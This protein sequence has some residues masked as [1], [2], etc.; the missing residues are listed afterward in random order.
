MS[1]IG[2]H[3]TAALLRFLLNLKGHGVGGGPR[4]R[5]LDSLQKRR[6]VY[7]I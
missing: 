3:V 7:A 4:R 1:I 2:A 5:A 6:G